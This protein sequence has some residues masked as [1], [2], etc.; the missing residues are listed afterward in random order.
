MKMCGGIDEEM[1]WKDF[2]EF[3]KKAK[4]RIA[5]LEDVKA[6]F[7]SLKNIF[8][9]TPGERVLLP[10]FGNKLRRLLYEGITPQNTEQIIAE[11]RHCVTEW[12]PR[13]V[14]QKI[15]NASTVEDTE[16]NTVHIEVEFT[17]PKLTEDYSYTYPITSKVTE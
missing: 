14:I 7:N 11:I 16:D 3:L 17:I 9:W 2:Q 15:M 13:V 1:F 4:Y 6:V 8:S 12:E 10:E 5:T